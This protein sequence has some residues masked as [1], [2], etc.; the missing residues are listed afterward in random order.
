MSDGITISEMSLLNDQT[1]M[2]VISHNLTNV[3]TTGFKQ[4]IAKTESFSDVMNIAQ[5]RQMGNVKNQQLRIQLPVIDTKID[6]SSGA[7]KYTG[8]PLNIALNNNLFMVIKTSHGNAYTRQ[9][10]LHIDGR[11]RLTTSNGLPVMGISGEIRLT[12]DKPVIDQQGRIYIDNENIAEFK[13]VHFPENSE[14]IPIG[15]ALYKTT[16]EVVINATSDN[17]MRQGYLEASNVNMT[18]EMIR[19]IEVTR[20]FESTQQL[21]KGYDDMMDNAINVIGDL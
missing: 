1:R 14:V 16:S 7:M 5:S 4:H 9:G 8:S 21:M 6:T 10:D 15:N 12:S 18:S 17:L 3:N 19:M 13:L 20:H 2:S 11:G